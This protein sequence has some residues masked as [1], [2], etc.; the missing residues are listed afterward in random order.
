VP[1]VGIGEVESVHEM[2]EAGNETVGN[3]LDHQRASAIE[4]F[5]LQV[6]AVRQDIPEALV[7]DEIAPLRANEPGPRDTDQEVSKRRRIQDAR[8]VDDDESHQ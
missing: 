7:E 8:V 3:R 4:R 1:I 2:L 6:R 5:G